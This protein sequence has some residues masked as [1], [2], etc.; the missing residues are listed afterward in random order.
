VV[1][2]PA[3]PLPRLDPRRI[4]DPAVL[5]RARLDDLAPTEAWTIDASNRELQYAT[6]GIFRFFGKF[7]PPIAAHLIDR[8]SAPGDLVLDPMV[9]SGTTAVEAL[10]AGRRAEVSDVSPLSVLLSRAKTTRVEARFAVAALDR[11]RSAPDVDPGPL[12]GLRNPAHWFLPETIRG[13]ARIRS[14]IEAV[15]EPRVRELLLTALLAIVRRASRATTQQG[16]LFLDEKTA[17]PDPWPAFERKARQAIAAVDALPDAWRADVRLAS[18][19]EEGE[20][21][22]APLCILHPPYFNNYKYSAVSSLELAWM[23]VD[24]A[25][26]RRGEVREAFKVGGIENA[27]RYVSDML[28]VLASC[29]QRVCRGG[30]LALMIGDATFRGEYLPL[31]REI[32]DGARDS[33]LDPELVAV[34]V[35]KFTEASWVAS[36][37]RTKARIGVSLHDFVVVMRR[38]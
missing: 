15:E 36:Q 18:A 16:R 19:M 4:G 33:G 20:G 5:R 13:L 8:Y 38:A 14:A 29:A 24:P 9:G 12:A 32:V 26:V 25:A 2:V 7:P 34:R 28:A 31:T 22:S 6:H 27:R 11:I 37:R 3:R 23:G 17:L 30:R 35:P 10:L 21:A 1:A